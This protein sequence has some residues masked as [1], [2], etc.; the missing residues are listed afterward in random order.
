MSRISCEAYNC[1]FN[2]DGGCRL[3]SIRVAGGDTGTSAGTVCSSYTDADEHGCISCA[4]SACACENCR[5]DCDAYD[6]RYNRD[7]ACTADRVHVGCEDAR[8]SD[9]TEC[10]TFRRA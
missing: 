9:D 5:I 10:K 8:C 4:P 7:C 3:G 2:R 1:D 6:C